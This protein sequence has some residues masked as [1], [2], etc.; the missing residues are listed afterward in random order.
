MFDIHRVNYTIRPQVL[1][2][3]LKNLAKKQNLDFE[4]LKIEKKFEK[5]KIQIIIKNQNEILAKFNSI[6]GFFDYLIFQTLKSE[7]ENNLF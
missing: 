4:N 3:L 7:T 1:E 2:L 6:T 5:N